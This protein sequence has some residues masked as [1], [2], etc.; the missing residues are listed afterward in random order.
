M[1]VGWFGFIM[2]NMGNLMMYDP[3]FD[4]WVDAW[5]DGFNM[6]NRYDPWMMGYPL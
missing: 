2:S 5:L 6:S 4:Q 1:N 3:N